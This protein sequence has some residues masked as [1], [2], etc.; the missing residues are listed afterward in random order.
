MVVRS[1]RYKSGTQ[2]NRIENIKR[3]N[4]YEERK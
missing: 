3:E 2:Q 1:R 4:S